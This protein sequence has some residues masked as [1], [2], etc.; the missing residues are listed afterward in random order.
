MTTFTPTHRSK[1]K[2]L[3]ERG[4]YDEESVFAILDAGLI[5]HI[6]YVIDGQPYVTP[7]A[8][9]RRGRQLYW[10][11]SSASRM[12]RAQV[13]EI[14]VCVTVSLLDGL[15]AQA[16]ATCADLMPGRFFLGVGTG[17]N[18]NEHVLGDRWPAP[19]ERLELL[20][21]AIELIR[22]LWRGKTTT[23]RGR[24]YTVDRARIFT[25]PE[26]PPE[27]AVAAVAPQAVE[28]AGRLGDIFVST[29]PDESVVARFEEAGG[30]DK[31]KLGMVHV[32]W[33][34]TSERAVEIAHEIWPN[35]ALTGPLNTELATPDDFAGA[36]EALSKE[37]VAKTVTHGPDVEPYVEEVR[38]FVDAGYDHVYFHQVGRDQEGFFR[39]FEQE[40]KP[41]L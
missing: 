4:R 25:L 3:H 37:D 20:E 35:S 1:V 18:L 23:H 11:G 22:E 9:W 14:P 34:E 33:A 32:C 17:E 29:A 15:V 39:F 19:D 16:A 2:R 36:V 7:T 6:G 28:L 5:A 10:H 40:L 30:R 21:E 38:S 41:R 26:E 12:L 27:I 24:G 13:K 8:Y 31:P